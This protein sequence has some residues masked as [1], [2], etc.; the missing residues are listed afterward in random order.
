MST[1]HTC[2]AEIFTRQ[3]SPVEHQDAE[4]SVERG[5]RA[6]AEAWSLRRL[7]TRL[8]RRLLGHPQRDAMAELDA[9]VQRLAELS[10]HLLVDVGIDPETGVMIDETAGIVVKRPVRVAQ[11]EQPAP[12]AVPVAAPKP[13]RLRLQVRILPETVETPRPLSV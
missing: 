10:P 8:A 3:L 2:I 7:A 12:V 13:A 5:H 11:P 9:A 4:S 1:T 6:E